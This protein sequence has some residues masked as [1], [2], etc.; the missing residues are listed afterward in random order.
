MRGSS[1]RGPFVRPLSRWMAHSRHP[2]AAQGR[3]GSG[4]SGM[5]ACL[6]MKFSYL[7]YH[8]IYTMSYK[9]NCD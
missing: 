2:P 8:F 3:L 1:P 7:F 6:Q 9:L 4:R 5:H